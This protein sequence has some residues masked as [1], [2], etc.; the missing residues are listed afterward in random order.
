MTPR[1]RHNAFSNAIGES[2]WGFQ[3]AMVAPAT[4]LT[5]LLRHY[6]AGERLIGSVGAIESGAVLLP[7]VVGMYLFTSRKKRKV[8][9]VLWHVLLMS[10]VLLVMGIVAPAPG[11]MPN[12]AVTIALLACFGWFQTAMGV[13]IAVWLDWLA[14]LFEPGIRGRVFGISWCCSALAGTAGALLAGHVISVYPPPVAFS[15]LYA[16]ASVF[17]VGSMAVFCLIKDPAADALD[18]APLAGTT[19]LLDSFRSSLGDRNFRSFIIGRI[20][21]IGGF[22]IV[23]FITV[24]YTSA[25]GGGLAPGTVVKLDAARTV[26]SSIGFLILGRMGDAA[27][28]RLGVMAGIAAQVAALAVVLVSAGRIS[29]MMAFFGAGLAA[30]GGFLSHTNMLYETCPHDSRIAH[31]TVGNLVMGVVSIL[32]PLLAGVAAARCGTRSL[33]AGCLLLSIAALL[34]FAIRV[35]EP[36]ELAVDVR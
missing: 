34:W 1:D 36:R 2:L 10:P 14:H 26:G 19:G 7:Q 29:C 8:R 12:R 25:A 4:V 16:A 27:G 28:H 22:C 15:C 6:G 32:C 23:P 31:I 13:I 18:D 24:Y 17:T 33:F 21:A 5:V 3:M 20:I 30:A 35:R 11:A 9:L